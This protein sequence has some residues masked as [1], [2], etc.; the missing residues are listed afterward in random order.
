MNRIE[1]IAARI[2][3]VAA[4]LD[5]VVTEMSNPKDLYTDFGGSKVEKT[6]RD[7]KIFG[8]K[9]VFESVLYFEKLVYFAGYS[10]RD[11]IKK[12]GEAVVEEAFKEMLR[13]LNNVIVRQI[14]LSMEKDPPISRIVGWKNKDDY[15]NPVC[16]IQSID[17]GTKVFKN[18]GE[19]GVDGRVTLTIEAEKM[20]DI[21]AGPYTVMTD[22]KLKALIQAWANEAPENFWMDGEYRG[23]AAAR[24]RGLMDEWRG[25]TPNQQVKHLADLKRWVR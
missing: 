6:F 13:L 14:S 8:N 24:V 25:M 4:V 15:S 22:V 12:Y 16:K 17:F 19:I 7:D 10:G 18:F 5:D 3:P 20:P 21:G 1:R 23:S 9:V 11:L 2:A